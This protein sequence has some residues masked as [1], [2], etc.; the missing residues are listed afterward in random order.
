MIPHDGHR[1]R[2]LEALPDARTGVVLAG[3]AVL[4]TACSPATPSATSSVTPT[5]T[6][7]ATVDV[8]AS[9]SPTVPATASDGATASA[10]TSAAA[11]ASCG[12]I[13]RPPLQS[14]SH[15]IG[16][17]APPVPYSSQPPTSGWH[18]S[19][20]VAVDVRGAADALTGP[21]QVSVLEAGGV[22]VS[23]G[24]LPDREA[25]RLARHIRRHHRGRVAVTPYAELGDGR[26]AFT[27]WGVL[28]RCDGVDLEA[29][30]A[31]VERFGPEGPVETGH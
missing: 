12:S 13:R 8:P 9:A 18:A 23:H 30:D 20:H 31:F 19:G 3:L 29:L 24:T 2:L 17:Q 26:V 6:A 27:S 11:V 4:L 15:L 25:R 1:A 10:P 5:P 7:A 22:V 16:D 14:G 28:Q 21:Q